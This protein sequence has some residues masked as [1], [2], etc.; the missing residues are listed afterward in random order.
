MYRIVTPGVTSD[1]SVTP[2]YVAQIAVSNICKNV[3]LYH[4]NVTTCLN[5]VFLKNLQKFLHV[6]MSLFVRIMT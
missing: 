2:T 3:S 6:T 4:S 5:D 1:I